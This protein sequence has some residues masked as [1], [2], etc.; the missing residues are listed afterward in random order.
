MVPSWGYPLLTVA[1]GVLLWHVVVRA[2]AI[3]DY[4]IPAPEAVAENLAAN[5]PFL[6]HHTLITTLETLGGFALSVIVGIPLAMVI[7]W[8]PK[9]DQALTPLLVL[10]QTFPKVAVAPLFIIWFGFGIQTKILVSFLIAFF[11]VVVATV[12][13]MRAVEPEMVELVRSMRASPLQV[14]FRLRMPAALPSIFAGMR[15]AIAFAVVGAVV[16]EWVGAD[17]GLGYLLLRANANLDTRLL[18]SILVMLTFVGVF[19]YYLVVWCERLAIPWHVSH[20]DDSFRP[21]A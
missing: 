11:P 3:P 18:F 5:W 2:F 14:F 16:G 19:L 7:V 13:G 10:S 20:R 4:L 1:A 17:R 15:V 8:S 9:I 21:P 6:W 12:A